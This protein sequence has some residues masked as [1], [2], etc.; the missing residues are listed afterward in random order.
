[1]GHPGRVLGNSPI[2]TKCLSILSTTTS[3]LLTQEITEFKSWQAMV[4]PPP[5]C[6]N[7]ILKSSNQGTFKY[8]VAS[9]S[10]STKLLNM[11][12]TFP[13]D[14]TLTVCLGGINQVVLLNLSTGKYSQSQLFLLPNEWTQGASIF[15]ITVPHSP[16]AAVFLRNSYT[17]MV[18][19]EGNPSSVAMFAAIGI[20]SLSL[21]LSPSLYLSLSLS[22]SLS[23][24]T[25]T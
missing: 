19:F 17:F 18:L 8:V 4:Y 25:T 16:T 20:L 21:S 1:M 10:G 7:S 5:C 22:L 12:L 6:S 9:W 13:F 2:Q 11:D 23:V 14:G 15:S 24:H 3:L